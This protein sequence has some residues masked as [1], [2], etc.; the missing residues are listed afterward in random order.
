MISLLFQLRLHTHSY[1]GPKFETLDY[2]IVWRVYLV[3]GRFGQ[4]ILVHPVGFTWSCVRDANCSSLLYLIPHIYFI[5]P[6]PALLQTAL[7]L[8]NER[9][10]PPPW[11]LGN[12]PTFSR[13]HSIPLPLHCHHCVSGPRHTTSNLSERHY[14]KFFS[15]PL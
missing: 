10:P 4:A 15:F 14:C 5:F 7:L 2:C 9:L 12:R 3:P 13:L 8:W 11:I 1:I 6:Y